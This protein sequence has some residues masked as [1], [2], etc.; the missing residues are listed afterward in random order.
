MK[1]PAP[2]LMALILV[3]PLAAN[4]APITSGDYFLG[5]YIGF[6]FISLTGSQSVE[7]ESGPVA[8]D[9]PILPAIAADI[10]LPDPPLSFVLPGEPPPLVDDPGPAMIYTEAEPSL[11]ATLEISSV[12]PDV[13]T[14]P[15]PSTVLLLGSGLA[16]L[17]A[18]GRRRLRR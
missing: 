15:D 1:R 18:Y 14:V 17:A 8:S 9:P 12:L 7:E 5:G 11:F 3:F 6:Q 13:A 2:I 16:A 4:A 10:G